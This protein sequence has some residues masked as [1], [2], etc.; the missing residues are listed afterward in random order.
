MPKSWLIAG[1]IIAIV[2]GTAVIA[3]VILGQN[4]NDE[5]STQ[6]SPS[7]TT[8]ETKLDDPD[9]VYDLFSDAS[10]TK[11]PESGAKFGNGQTLTFEYDGSKTE[12]D[13]YTNL[14]YQLYYIQ[15]DGKVQPMG[16]AVLDGKGEGTFSTSNS[17]FNSSA[18]DRKGF[19]ELIA[20]YQSPSDAGQKDASGL[21][22]V[23]EVKLGMYSITF[24]VS[25]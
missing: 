5:S 13:E 10:V 4:K 9:G 14:S 1:G 12:H 19:L 16:G 2:I 23:R 18:K 11:H 8:G 3:S 17:V 20:N 25:E 6:N 24:D 15:E 22:K 21:P 7:Q